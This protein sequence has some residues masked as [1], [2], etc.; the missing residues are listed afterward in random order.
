MPSQA[1]YQ[2]Y[3]STHGGGSAS[4]NGDTPSVT[5]SLHS[6]RPSINVWQVFLKVMMIYYL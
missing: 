6:K 4:V 5:T 2:F 1:F 3:T